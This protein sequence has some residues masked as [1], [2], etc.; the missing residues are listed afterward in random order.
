[1]LLHTD[2]SFLANCGDYF[3]PFFLWMLGAF[4]LGY[5]LRYFLGAKYRAR[6]AELEKDVAMWKSKANDLEADLSAAKYDRE[7]T[8]EELA[9]C[10]R[11]TGDLQLK[12]QA[13]LESQANA[14]TASANFVAAAPIPTP[15]PEIQKVAS[16]GGTETGYAAFLKSDNLQV[17]EGIGPK[18]EGLLKAA[19][20]NTWKE[21][22]HT[23]TAKVAAILEE[24]GPRYRI[25]DPKTWAEQARLADGGKWDELIKYQKFLGGGKDS[26]NIN[27][28]S[29][30]LEKIYM[31][32]RG[33]KAF[34][35]DD[36]KVVEG[37]GPKIEGL[38]KGAG[39]NNHSE[40][41][42]TSVDKIKEVLAAA[43]D[44]YRLADPTTWPKQA[45][46]ASEGKWEELKQWQDELDG[47]K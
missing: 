18:I 1:M 6:V 8:A 7:K 21:L 19:G 24:A 29:S 40:L 27:S 15:E 4:I 33:L 43:G 9:A 2:T 42:E 17:V 30:K 38:L 11:N 41:A 26:T 22:A 20:I 34:A 28:G 37:I 13:C 35:A 31:K 44:R 3:W 32:A 47:G 14:P 25:H 5:L 46:L 39:I 45:Q 36:L 23:D 16:S 12:L 10:K